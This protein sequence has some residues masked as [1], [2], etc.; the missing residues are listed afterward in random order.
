MQMLDFK[1]TEKP[2]CSKPL[3][4]G[5]NLILK[6]PANQSGILLQPKEAILKYFLPWLRTTRYSMEYKRPQRYGFELIYKIS[7]L[8]IS[9]HYAI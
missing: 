5:Y 8:I 4:V 3:C 2:A 7:R 1:M 9:F 6:L